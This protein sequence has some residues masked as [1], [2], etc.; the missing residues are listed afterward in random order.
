MFEAT[1]SAVI[2]GMALPADL[3][4]RAVIE[5]SAAVFGSDAARFGLAVDL[6]HAEQRAR[7]RLQQDAHCGMLPESL[8]PGM[9]EAQRLRDAAFARTTLEAVEKSGKPV[10]VITGT[11]HARDDWGMP[12]ALGVAAP[13]LEVMTIGQFEESVPAAARF[14]HTLVSSPAPRKDPCEAL[15]ER[16]PG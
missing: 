11:G 14:D 6:P 4:N 8:L 15:L 13:Q 3:V 7:E 10:I 5:G 16:K 1:G 12:A 9:V 2:Y